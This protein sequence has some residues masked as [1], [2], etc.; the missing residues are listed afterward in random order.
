MSHQRYPSQ[1]RTAT[2][3]GDDNNSV[4]GAASVTAYLNVTAVPGTDTVTL[5]LEGKDPLS[6]T[7]YTVLQAAARSTTGMDA[8]TFGA[9]APVVANQSTGAPVPRVYRARVVHS[10]GTSFT[11]SLSVQEG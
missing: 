9:G 11:Y 4:P 5:V 7:Y 3:V 8:L 1:A 6:G 10:A 2:F